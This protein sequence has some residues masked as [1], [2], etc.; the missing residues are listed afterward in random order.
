MNDFY[1]IEQFDKLSQKEQIRICQDILHRP[2]FKLNKNPLI[3]SDLDLMLHI[4]KKH[5]KSKIKLSN[6]DRIEV[7]PSIKSR[8]Y[9]NISNYCFHIVYIDGSSDDISYRK[10]LDNNH[11]KDRKSDP[12]IPRYLTM[13]RRVVGLKGVRAIPRK[14]E[15]LEAAVLNESLPKSYVVYFLWEDDHLIY[16]GR[17]KN[18]LR[19]MQSDNHVQINEPHIKYISY[20]ECNSYKETIQLETKYIKKLTRLMSSVVPFLKNDCAVARKVKKDLGLIAECRLIRL[21]NG[22]LE[23]ERCKVNYGNPKNKQI[24]TKLNNCRS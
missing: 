21:S 16:V 22:D 14:V 17:S 3:G 15:N 9:N 18:L 24:S 8:R 7:R 11:N 20:I 12:D 2:D 23:C 6:M 10:C 19:R 5:P 4:F 1:T 13:T